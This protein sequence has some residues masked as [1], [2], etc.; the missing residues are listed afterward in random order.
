[1]ASMGAGGK[2]FGAGGFEGYP[3]G[4]GVL[5]DLTRCVG[6][7]TCEAACNKEQGLP[8]PSVPFDDSSVFEGSGHGNSQKR[9]PD[10]NAYTVVN[11]YESDEWE[12]PVYRKVQCNHCNEPSCLTACFVNAYTKTEQGAVIYNPDVC[13]G[14]RTC[15]IACPFRIPAYEYSNAL[16]PVVRKCILC[17]E[18]RLKYG[19]PPA[20]VAACPKE[21][22]TFGH[23]K[24]L[25]K[26]AHE[27]IRFE[28]DKYV[29]HLYG[30]TEVGGTTWMYL[31]GVP[32]EELDFD[33]TLQKEPI[34]KNAAEFL[35]N[36]PMVLSIWPAMFLGFH[37][38]A[39]G[40]H[41]HDADNDQENDKD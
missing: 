4:M 25:T 40:D 7:R 31:S 20:C 36:V 6:C 24:N 15:M 19:R 22:M 5:V 11:R 23:R 30:E 41:D 3:D 10:E 13:V 27:R 17:Y 16:N 34:L 29:D 28:P 12:A 1:V 2:A 14:C 32:F 39:R 21:V 37:L 8:D 9:R 35:T 33:T 26:V 18:T 38:L